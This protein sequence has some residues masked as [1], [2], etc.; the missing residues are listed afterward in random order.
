[1]AA[2]A[3]PFSLWACLI[4]VTATRHAANSLAWAGIGNTFFWIDPESNLCAVIL[5]QSAPFFDE[6]AIRTL[7]AFEA[8]VYRR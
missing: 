8:A 7:Q 5:M 4:R 1:M 2:T 3:S 6:P